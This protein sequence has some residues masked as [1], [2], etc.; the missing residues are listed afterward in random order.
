MS[1]GDGRCYGGL[2][3]QVL[4][5]WDTS[6]MGSMPIAFTG[7]TGFGGGRGDFT[8]ELQPPGSGDVEDHC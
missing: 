6:G 7:G 3:A 5:R 2:T 1:D 4:G 8:P